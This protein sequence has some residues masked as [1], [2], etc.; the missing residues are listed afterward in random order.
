LETAF[1]GRDRER[2]GAGAPFVGTECEPAS[3][4]CLGVEVRPGITAGGSSD[5]SKYA[6]AAG[7]GT[8]SGDRPRIARRRNSVTTATIVLATF[9]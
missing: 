2:L 3:G 5:S 8:D 4:S 9:S 6:A 1:S 7:A